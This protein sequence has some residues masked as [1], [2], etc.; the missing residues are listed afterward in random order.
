[1]QFRFNVEN[2]DY[3]TKFKKENKNCLSFTSAEGM[4]AGPGERVPPACFRDSGSRNGFAPRILLYKHSA[5]AFNILL[6]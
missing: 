6:Q 5:M 2:L 3:T 1:M 4:A